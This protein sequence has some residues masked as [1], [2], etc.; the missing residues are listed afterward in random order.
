[1]HNLYIRNLFTEGFGD[2][3]FMKYYLFLKKKVKNNFLLSILTGIHV[4]FYLLFI[5]FIT[6]IIFKLS[7]PL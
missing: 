2:I 3:F 5:I 7:W 1:M 6:V 4:A